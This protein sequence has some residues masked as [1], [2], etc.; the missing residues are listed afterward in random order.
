[1]SVRADDLLAWAQANACATEVDTRAAVSRAYYA[2]YHRCREWHARLPSPG[3]NSG[4]GGG[5]HQQLLNQLRNPAPQC[6]PTQASLSRQLAYSLQALKADRF[7]ADYE[8]QKMVRNADVQLA[9][10]KAAMIFTKAV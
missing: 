10:A 4:P 7:T 8:L 3:F 1:M 5:V 2:A 6:S 9:C